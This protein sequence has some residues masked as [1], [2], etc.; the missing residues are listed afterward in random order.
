MATATSIDTLCSSCGKRLRVSAEHAGRKARCP[1]CQLVYTVPTQNMVSSAGYEISLPA[2]PTGETWQVKSPEGLIYGPVSK[3]E[4]DG[5]RDAG[6]ISH[7]SQ[8]LPT[9]GGEWLWAA[10]IYPELALAERMTA[11]SQAADAT[12]TP[13]PSLHP[14]YGRGIAP[15]RGPLVLA[16]AIVSIFTVCPA[17]SL[18]GLFL[19]L[20]DLRLMK[21]EKMDPS[22]RG[23]TLAG[24]IL[25]LAFLLLTAGLALVGLI[26]WLT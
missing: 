3:Q 13:A 23:L 16:M 12:S 4:L 19:G 8:L 22:G 26:A 6:R 15:H 2:P 20:Y 24:I 11:I 9:G 10:E 21:Q 7:R 17:P 14:D 25:S 18:I 5:W 1:H